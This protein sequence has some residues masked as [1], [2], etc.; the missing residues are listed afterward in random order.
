MDFLLLPSIPIHLALAIQIIA[1][2]PLVSRCADVKG[3]AQVSLIQAAIVSSSIRYYESLI[4]DSFRTESPDDRPE[5][6]APDDAVVV[7]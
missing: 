1:V 3:Q 2:K 5:P 6:P 4:C 7:P